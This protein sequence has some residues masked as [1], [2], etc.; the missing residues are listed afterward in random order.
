VRL[1]LGTGDSTLGLKGMDP[2]A[3][4]EF[5][6]CICSADR[7]ETKPTDGGTVGLGTVFARAGLPGA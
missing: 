6:F 5:A 7:D 1:S 2:T 4:A 3:A